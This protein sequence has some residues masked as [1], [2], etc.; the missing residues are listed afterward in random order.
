MAIANLVPRESGSG[1]LGT[2]DKPWGEVNT[3]TLTAEVANIK[4]VEGIIAA[5]GDVGAAWSS[6]SGSPS[7]EIGRNDDFYINVV[8][9][10]VYQKTSGSWIWKCRLQGAASTVT[11]NTVTAV[12]ADEA[13]AITNVGTS[14]DAVLNFNLPKGSYWLTGSGV[15]S[16]TIGGNGDM[17]LNGLKG[18]VYN[19]AGGVW[20]SSVAN[21]MGPP[22]VDGI[23][24][25]DGNGDIM[26]K[27]V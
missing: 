18:D 13:P 22:G 9:K 14:T 7:S 11:V 24:E 17:Y 26:P 8:T 16:N 12:A 4:Y 2:T 1:K 6:G 21:I 23:Y 3:V 19:K 10:D 5:K 15:P 20:G 27:V 25:I